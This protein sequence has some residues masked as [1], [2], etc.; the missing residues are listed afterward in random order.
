MLTCTW[1][2]KKYY[3]HENAAMALRHEIFACIFA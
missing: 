2:S 1:D 3:K